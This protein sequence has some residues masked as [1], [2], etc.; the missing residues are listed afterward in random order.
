MN[1]EE[2]FQEE[3]Q[4]SFQEIYELGYS[5]GFENAMKELNEKVEHLENMM[6]DSQNLYFDEEYLWKYG[7]EIYIDDL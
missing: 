2:N 6:H 4:K 5:I 3:L 7:F 1:E